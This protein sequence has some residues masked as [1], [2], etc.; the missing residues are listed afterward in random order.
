MMVDNKHSFS[1]V[2]PTFNESEKITPC[3]AGII[4]GEHD[5][6]IIV[7]DGGSSDNTTEI[8]ETAGAKVIH[9]TRC[10]GLQCNLGAASATGEILVFLHADTKLPVNT[11]LYLS[12]IFSK[13]EVNIGNFKIVFDKRHW[14]LHFWSF[15]S[16]F[17]M[18]LFRF[19]DQGIV[20][21]KTLFNELGGFPNW[22]L[23]EDFK[24]IRT[25][26]KKTRIH[27]FP[28]SVT[29]S[30]RRFERNGIIRQQVKNVYYTI[31]YLLGTSPHRLAEKYY[32]DKFK[33]I[34]SLV[35]FLRFP[36]NGEVKTR[37]ARTIGDEIATLFYRECVE[38]LFKEV[39]KLPQD[40]A[41]HIIYTPRRARK[42]VMGWAGKSFRYQPQISGDLGKRLMTIFR[43]QLREGYREVIITATD[44]PDLTVNDIEETFNALKEVDLVIG[45]SY[46]GGYYL[47]GMKEF[48]PSLF[49][50]ITWST[51]AVYDQTL[52]KA[53]ELGLKVHILRSLDDIDTENDLRRW[54][55]RSF[56]KNSKPYNLQK[57]IMALLEKDE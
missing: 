17:D 15:V 31:Q 56:L 48:Y 1:V 20:I 38:N 2:I 43:D 16:R 5:V 57:H 49:N 52:A 4:A 55:K 30:T 51:D 27:R 41:R 19:G 3:I 35:I 45:P 18:G 34:K 23:F 50:D 22:T 37:L 28:I 33:F 46:D 29:T 7:V 10:R 42:R 32:D 26:R 40:V 14:F 8:A 44:V 39:E 6:E 11:F 53:E 13:D 36:I 12:E 54:Q 25:A 9:T 21:R 24:L 47:I